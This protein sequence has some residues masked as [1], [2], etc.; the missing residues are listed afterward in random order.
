MISLADDVACLVVETYN[1]LPKV[2]KPLVRTNGLAEWTM[3]AGV[4]VK[5]EGTQSERGSKI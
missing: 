4:V 5:H 1:S 3:I 2:G